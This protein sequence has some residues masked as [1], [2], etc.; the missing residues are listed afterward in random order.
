MRPQSREALVPGPGNVE[1]CL[2][3][4]DQLQLD[5]VDF[6]SQAHSPEEF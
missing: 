3:A 1:E 4:A 6:P 2:P 5:T